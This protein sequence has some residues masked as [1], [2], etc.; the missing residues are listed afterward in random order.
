MPKDAFCAQLR[1]DFSQDNR[2]YIWNTRLDCGRKVNQG[3]S[4]GFSSSIN[5]MLI[6]RS[7]FSNNR[8][9]W[10]EDGKINLNLDYTLTSRLKI[11][12]LFSQDIN[13]LEKRKVTS[14][15]YGITT[16]YNISGV[17]F[18]QIIG[19]KDIHRRLEEGKRK[20]SGF[21][22]RLKI[23]H[24]PLI[25]SESVTHISFSQTSSQLSNIPLLERDFSIFFSKNFSEEDSLEFSY[26]EGWS[27]K[28]FYWGDL[29]DSQINTQ[30]RTQRVI[31][32]RSSTQMPFDIRVNFDFDFV[33]SG[34]KYS[35]EQ[36]LGSPGLTDNF[37]NS[38]NFSLKIKRQ[39]FKRL[40]LGSSYKY[41]ETDMDYADD[42][43]DQKMKNGELGGNLQI[44]I[45]EK[46]SLYLAASIGVTS[47]Y[48]PVSAQFN[49]RD[50]LTLFARGEYLH[51]FSPIF[52]LRLEGGFR[53]FHQIYISNRL[54]ANNNH[55]QTYLLSPTLIWRPHPNLYFKQNY[56]IQANY[57]YYD[58]EKSI[59]ST[60]N[61]LFR[62]ASSSTTINYRILPWMSFAFDY[63]YRYEDYGQL[64]WRDQWVQKPSWERRTHTFSLSMKYMPAKSWVFSP[65]YTYQKRKSWDHFTDLV[66]LKKSRT[67][68]DRFYRNMISFSC[69]YFI[70]DRNYISLT[71]ARRVQ[72][73]TL[74]SKETSDYA[75]VSVSR[76]F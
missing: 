75:T 7:V 8:D 49:D 65:E 9:R 27:K 45:S 63:I 58:Y 33:S 10:Q 16:Q 47:F 64:I 56:N 6:K 60:K 12:A 71:G 48:A 53:N 23:A 14:S 38:Q 68:R 66:T 30:R 67:L 42:Q 4:W 72:K 50:I 29:T 21:Y 20:D 22:H 36:N 3:L 76:I 70:D 19:G 46:D 15:E 26:R 39:F 40:S 11:G 24:S 18:V 25:L 41:L 74:S 13:S 2:T 57:I 73:S 51:V 59:E 5:S 1:L 52:S 17:K 55:N 28:K 43:K 32:L 31:N 69:K 34:Y 44:K 61:R 54:S 35:G 37:S 62:R